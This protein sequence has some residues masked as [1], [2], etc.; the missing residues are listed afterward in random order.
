MTGSENEYEC[1]KECG[2]DDETWNECR[3]MGSRTRAE[4]N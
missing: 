4:R 3:K 2:K 1:M